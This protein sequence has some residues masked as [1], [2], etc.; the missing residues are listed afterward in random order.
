ML[1]VE[2]HDFVNSFIKEKLLK[3]IVDPN[4]IE[5]DKILLKN[6]CIDEGYLNI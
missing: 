4:R 5:N 2:N 3:L 1:D 6:D